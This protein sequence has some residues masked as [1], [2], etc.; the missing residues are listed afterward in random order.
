MLDAHLGVIGVWLAFVAC[1]VGI[2]TIAFGL[3]PGRRTAAASASPR[4]AGVVAAG[5]GRL[6]APVILVGGLLAAGAMEH[7]L[8]THD[9]TLAFVAENNS[10]VTPL[11]YSITG[12]WSALAGSILLWGLV[13]GIVSTIFVV[14]YRHQWSDTVIRWATLTLY[15]VAA[16]FFGLMVGPANPFTTAPG[17]TQGLGPNSLLQDNPL[18]A[19]HPPLLYCG[20]VLFTVPFAFAIGMLATGRVG[21]RWQIECRRW[22]L[23][24]FT[25]LSVGIV[26]GAWWSYQVLGWGGFWGWDPVEN[27]ALL[28]W[29]CGTAYLHSVLVQERRGLMRVWNLSLSIATFALTILGTFLTRSGVITS[30]HAFSESSLGPLLIGFFFAVVIVGFGLI[31]WRGDRLRSPGGID[32]PL[33]REGAFLLN[34]VLFVGFAFVVLLGT[35]YPLLYEAVTQQQVTVGAPFFNTVAVPVGLTLLFLMAVAPVLSW[36]KMSGTVLWH[37]LALPVWVGVG[38]VVLC[39]AFGLRGTATLIG[40]GL[41]AMAAATAARALVLSV[42]GAQG[43]HVG[44]WRGLVGRTNGGMIVH[45]GVVVLAVGVIAATSYRHQAELALHRGTVVTYDGHRFEFEGLKTVSAPSRTSEEALVKVDDAVF[46]PATTS[47]GSALSTVGTPAIDSGLFGDVYLTFD[48]VGGLGATSGNQPVSNLPSGSVAIGV[49]I[50]PLVAWLWAGGLLIGAGGLLAL[51][52]AR[53]TDRL[54]ARGWLGWAGLA[55]IVASQFVLK[56]STPFPGWIALLPVAGA[57]AMIAGG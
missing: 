50:E 2:A 10:T 32:A 38:T 9:F 55:M 42:R 52:P 44:W 46:A 23:V 54:G 5:D 8:V 7:A 18:V 39:V 12:L 6:L 35:L 31:A 16:F 26:L 11:L 29:L 34:N 4:G 1:L 47:F 17:V 15:V 3:L 45:L 25:F 30:V 21:D 57:L 40:F 19:I 27:A 24:A 51:L 43:H 22:T 41:G 14:R 53:I 49:V 48:A 56:G 33:G 28:P 13:L 36:R 37:R 20:F